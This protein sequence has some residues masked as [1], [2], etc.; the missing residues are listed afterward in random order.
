L[1]FMSKKK[2]PPTAFSGQPRSTG[3]SYT[4]PTELVDPWRNS[5]RIQIRSRFHPSPPKFKSR[6]PETQNPRE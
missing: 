2:C 3:I 6:N 5:K 1:L 4:D